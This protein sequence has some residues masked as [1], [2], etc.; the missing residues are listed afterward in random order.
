[1]HYFT[2]NDG[3]CYIVALN[4]GEYTLMLYDEE[5]YAR[6]ES[7][8]CQVVGAPSSTESTSSQLLLDDQGNPQYRYTFHT[9]R[10]GFLLYRDSQEES[11]VIPVDEDGDGVADYGLRYRSA[12][13]DESG[14]GAASFFETVTLYHPDNTPLEEYAIQAE[15]LLKPA[16]EMQAGWQKKDGKLYY[17]NSKGQVL[18]GLQKLDGKLYYFNQYGEKARSL[19]VDVSCFNGR[20]NWSLVR[21]QGIDFAIIR[22]G[23]RGWQSGLAYTDTQ[24]SDHLAGARAAGLQLGVYFYS[25]AATPDEA[26]QEADMILSQLDGMA[27]DLPI[28]FDMEFSGD[29]PYGR[30]DQLSIAQRMD[31][32]HAFCRV[33]TAGGYEAGVYSGESFLRTN[34][35]YSAISRYS[36]WLANYTENNA[37]PSYPYPFHIWQFTEQGIVSGMGSTVDLNV[38]F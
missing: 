11:D 8:R 34:I 19:G 20:V 1:M 29:Y 21:E 28:Y 38:I 13:E 36:I 32:V 24:L 14:S 15:P 16:S 12:A 17:Y 2:T 26:M 30:A 23:G 7:V 37:L 27:L 31:I 25:T 9:G 35:D 10:N 6:C 18:T 5:G 3:S 4:P 33:I 22:V